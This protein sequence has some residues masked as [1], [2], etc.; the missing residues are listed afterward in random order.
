[1]ATTASMTLDGGRVIIIKVN[2][3]ATCPIETYTFTDI[4]IGCHL[5]MYVVMIFKRERRES[6]SERD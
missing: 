2:K 4:E 5:L 3:I 6:E 1:M